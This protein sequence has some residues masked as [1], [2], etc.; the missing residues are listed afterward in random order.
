MELSRQGQTWLGMETT[1]KRR[2]SLAAA[3]HPPPAE[4]TCP[5]ALL[6]LSIS[7]H[8][9]PGDGQLQPWLSGLF[10]QQSEELDTGTSKARVTS[11]P[12]HYKST[13]VSDNMTESSQS[14]HNQN[15]WGQQGPLEDTWPKPCS[16]RVTQNWLLGTVS[17]W[18]LSMS[19]VGI[20][21]I[22]LN[23]TVKKIC[24]FPQQEKELRT[25][26][27]ANDHPL[28]K[29]LSLHNSFPSLDQRPLTRLYK[30]IHSR[31]AAVCYSS[32]L[33]LYITELPQ[34]PI[35]AFRALRVK[36][37]TCASSVQGRTRLC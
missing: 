26:T 5:T 37:P 4:L 33:F 23:L 14:S 29:L 20:W 19:K 11:E 27:F 9:S 34:L 21:W 15:G 1:G 3:V 22:V 31:K 2:L 24:S 10:T 8:G 36:N 7:R 32:I 13:Q 30:F 35:P 17:K 6:I 16:S 12:G 25:F 18:L 28:I